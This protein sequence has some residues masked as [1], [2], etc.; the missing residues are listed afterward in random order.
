MEIKP[1][2]ES[3]SLCGFKIPSLPKTVFNSG[4]KSLSNKATV[5]TPQILPNLEMSKGWGN[6]LP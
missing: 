6:G 2:Q 5:V 3:D 1:G 4:L